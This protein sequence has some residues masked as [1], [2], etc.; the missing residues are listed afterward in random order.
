MTSLTSMSEETDTA[1][2][3]VHFATERADI[4]TKGERT[5]Q[6][7]LELAVDRFGAQGYRQ[8]S[9]SE[10]ARAAGLTQA[11][12]YAYFENKQALFVA[13]LDADASALVLEAGGRAEG[14]PI[15]QLPLAFL[16]E[17]FEGVHDHP[18][19]R[20]VLAGQETETHAF[21]ELIDLP[22]VRLATNEIV[23]RLRDAQRRG[24]VRPDLD[25]EQ[26]GAGMEAI[27]LSILVATVQLGELGTERRQ[28]GI[29]AAFAAML[30]PIER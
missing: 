20:R 25:P 19:S 6:R 28:R 22:A 23:E 30:D 16:V 2:A 27:I 17:L 5:R 29:V 24:E 3:P 15:T 1:G 8:T 9:V 13:A 4:I 11:T 14:T 21:P 12:V 7:L 10:I 18:L 26:I